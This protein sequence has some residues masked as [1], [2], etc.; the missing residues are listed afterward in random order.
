MKSGTIAPADSTQPVSQP[1]NRA[2]IRNQAVTGWRSLRLR[3]LW[4]YRELLYFLV[5]RDIKV[6][7]K[8]TLLGAFWAVIQPVITMVVFSVFIGYL[9]SV[10]SD[11][12]PYPVFNY[13]ALVPWMFFA[14][15]L[16]QAAASLT[17]NA[18]LISKVYFPRLLI[19]TAAVMSGLVDFAVAFLL[20]FVLLAIYGVVPSW[21]VVWIP[22]FLLLTIASSLGAGLWLA[23]WNARFRDARHALPFLVQL[24]MFATPVVYPSSLLPERWRI[25]YGLNPMT[26]AIEGFRWA[27][28]GTGNPPGLMFVVSSLIA[29]LLLVSGALYFRRIE[30]LFAEVL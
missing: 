22:A 16:T 20:V 7:Y 4:D 5:W 28:L 26:A 19:P 8:Q 25:V 29:V 6:R 17:A 15:A 12:V 10:P 13:V 24:W 1:S 27:L 9:A 11:G 3:E 23:A 21:G 18:H 2:F 30:R 14:G